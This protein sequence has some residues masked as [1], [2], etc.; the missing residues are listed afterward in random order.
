MPWK[1]YKD[2][3]NLVWTGELVNDYLLSPYDAARNGVEIFLTPGENQLRAF[4]YYKKVDFLLGIVGGAML[5]LYLILW[6]PFNYINKT[7]HQIRNTS[8]LILVNKGRDEDP[9]IV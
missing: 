7:I 3:S 6:V 1:N 2:V 5:L 8:Q 9:V 4:R